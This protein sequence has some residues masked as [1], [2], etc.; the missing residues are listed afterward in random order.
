MNFPTKALRRQIRKH[1]L[2]AWKSA[3]IAIH[4]TFNLAVYCVVF[5]LV[6]SANFLLRIQREVLDYR[7]QEQHGSQDKTETQPSSISSNM[8]LD[9]NRILG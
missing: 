8:D 4:C 2:T 6:A 3:S 9:R 1:G 7:P 5:L